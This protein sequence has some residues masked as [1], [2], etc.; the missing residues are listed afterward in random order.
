MANRANQLVILQVRKILGSST[1]AVIK[2]LEA[3]IERLETKQAAVDTSVTDDIEI[4]DDLAEEM[5][6]LELDEEA[7]SD[8]AVDPQ[9]LPQN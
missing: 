5:A 7:L 3:L 6:D 8:D 4:I 1:Y 2:Y 9:S